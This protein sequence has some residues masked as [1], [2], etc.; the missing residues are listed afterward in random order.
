L[1]LE[2]GVIDEQTIE[3]I[4]AFATALDKMSSPSLPLWFRGVR[5]AYY[6]LSPTLY[7]RS[8]LTKFAEFSALEQRLLTEF[9]HRSPPFVGKIPTDE[10]ELLFLMQHHSV[11]TR[12][13]DWTENPFV[14]LF[15]ALE[16]VRLPETQTDAAVWILNPLLL[17]K[18]SLS[19]YTHEGILSVGDDLLRGYEP[20]KEPR[21]PATNPIALYGVH[22]SQ[23]IVAQRGVFVLSAMNTTPLNKI[24]FTDAGKGLLRKMTIPV[25][26]KKPIFDQLFAMGITDSVLFPDLDGLAREIKTRHGF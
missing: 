14:A 25:A 15:F 9:K 26:N 12:L 6:D 19:S 4:A 3:S 18:L 10:L 20:M 16:A 13:L 23:R 8:D 22:N 1:A 5:H 21:T 7:R 11:P 17:N 24:D 2:A